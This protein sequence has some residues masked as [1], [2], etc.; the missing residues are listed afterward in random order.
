MKIK[1]QHLGSTTTT[2]H[3]LELEDGPI[4]DAGNSYVTGTKFQVRT[5][6]R[7]RINSDPWGDVTVAGPRLKKDGT[8]GDLVHTRVFV[9]WKGLPEWLDD[10]LKQGMAEFILE[11]AENEQ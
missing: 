5:I 11:G 10:I 4:I 8:L 1:D 6:R 9:A 2:Y 3:R 7:R